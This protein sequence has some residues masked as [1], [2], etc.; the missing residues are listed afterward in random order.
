MSKPLPR[1]A[2]LVVN[3]MS[4]RGA[5]VFEEARDKL[6]AAGIDLIDAHAV[7][8]PEDMDPTVKK[9]I[10][11]APMVIVGGGDGSLSTNVDHFVGKDTV[12]AI[13][14]LGTANSFAKTLGMTTDLDAA[15]DVIANGQRKRIDLGMIDDDYFANAAALGLSPLIADTV[16][17]KLK[18]YLGMV[19]YLFWAAR[20]AFKFRPFRLRVTLEDGSCVKAW[21][22]EA[23]IFN[24]THHG[25]VELTETQA[26]DSGEIVIQAVTGKSLWGLAWS[27]FATLFKL[28]NREMTTT[29]WRGTSMRLEARPRQKISID[30]EISAKTPV[31]VHIADGVIE[32][33]AP[34]D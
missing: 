28:R 14:P 32:V 25:G 2:I 22:T 11:R 31:T 10:E 33:A 26:L 16:P 17:H 23:R 15:I 34:K 6:I 27:W 20:V 29:E 4:R 1:Q 12:F 9:A 7:D 21:A 8:K 5:D 3:A 19:G 30:G 13:L 18:K 24:G